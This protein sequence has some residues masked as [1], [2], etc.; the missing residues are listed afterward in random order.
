ML[1]LRQAQIF[2]ALPELPKLKGQADLL[3][4]VN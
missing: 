3:N 2:K 4:S 1:M